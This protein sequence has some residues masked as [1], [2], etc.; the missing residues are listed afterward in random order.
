MKLDHPIQVGSQLFRVCECPADSLK[1]PRFRRLSP[2]IPSHSARLRPVGSSVRAAVVVASTLPSAYRY[3]RECAP[4]ATAT[5]DAPRKLPGSLRGLGRP[6]VV[7]HGCSCSLYE[8]AR[9]AARSEEHTSEL[10]SRQYLVCRLLL[11]KKEKT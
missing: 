5:E 10:Q 9:N 6:S 4:A 1:G 2:E 3:A 7:L 8:L 11:E